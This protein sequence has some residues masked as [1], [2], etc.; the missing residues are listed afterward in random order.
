MAIAL[1]PKPVP[2]STPS[3]SPW[4]APSRVGV[5]VEVGSQ[6]VAAS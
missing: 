5:T 6:S 1:A 2:H 4:S 3:S